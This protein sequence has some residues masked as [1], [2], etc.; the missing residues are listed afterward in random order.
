MLKY[1]SEEQIRIFSVLGIKIELVSLE[2]T[3]K[4]LEE[5]REAEFDHWFP[6][7]MK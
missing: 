5:I 2:D 7:G 6:D 1:Y 3:I 4:H